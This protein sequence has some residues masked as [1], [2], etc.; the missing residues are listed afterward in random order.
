MSIS[1]INDITTQALP[2]L[3]SASSSGSNARTKGAN[4]AAQI[5]GGAMDLNVIKELIAGKMS[6]DFFKLTPAQ[7]AALKRL[8]QVVNLAEDAAVSSVSAPKKYTESDLLLMVGDK[9]K[10]EGAAPV[11]AAAFN[12]IKNAF[13]GRVTEDQYSKVGKALDQLASGVLTLPMFNDLVRE[14]AGEKSPMSGVI[15]QFADK[16]KN[17][18]K[19]S[20]ADLIDLV[21]KL[22]FL[23][24]VDIGA[25]LDSNSTT[26]T[27]G[28][29]K[30]GVAIDI[31]TNGGNTKV[32]T[33]SNLSKSTSTSG[34]STST[35]T[36]TKPFETVAQG[37]G[38]TN[39]YISKELAQGVF[40]D[41]IRSNIEHARYHDPSLKV[42]YMED[43]SIIVNVSTA[44][45]TEFGYLMQP[46][47][48]AAAVALSRTPQN[49]EN[50]TAYVNQSMMQ[51]TVA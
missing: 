15:A 23:L 37:D 47:L 38:T 18:E 21:L 27:L 10:G 30:G 49:L 3:T 50:L 7:F 26:P 35:Y 42:D 4:I 22:A 40:G 17:F 25:T 48:G 24:G 51:S 9:I 1:N 12:A 11:M 31:I 5:L 16:L 2:Q 44:K 45:A 28:D 33:S 29:K 39:F 19:M 34:N 20:D 13:N 8:M 41:Y 32:T 6:T 36:P 46:Y 14:I 43:G